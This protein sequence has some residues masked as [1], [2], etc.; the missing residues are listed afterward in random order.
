[1]L[2]IFLTAISGSLSGIVAEVFPNEHLS[3]H[4]IIPNDDFIYILLKKHLATFYC[5][6]QKF[7]TDI[8]E[9]PDVLKS[10][11]LKSTLALFSNILGVYKI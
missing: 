5:H 4:K 8:G 11:K 7:Y 2:Y 1:M 10:S 3:E 6:D 9:K